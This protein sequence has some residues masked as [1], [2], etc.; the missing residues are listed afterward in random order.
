MHLFLVLMGVGLFVSAIGAFVAL[1]RPSGSKARELAGAAIMTL[2]GAI[3]LAGC[4]TT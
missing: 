1:S 3:F 4:F 2:G